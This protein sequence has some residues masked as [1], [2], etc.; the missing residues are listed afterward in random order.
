MKEILDL[1]KKKLSN[2]NNLIV[3]KTFL[4]R[5]GVFIFCYIH[6]KL[7]FLSVHMIYSD[8]GATWRRCLAD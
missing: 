3:L 4:A 1:I 2:I 8:I 6:V 7:H 5:L